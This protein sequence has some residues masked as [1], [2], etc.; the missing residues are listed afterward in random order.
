MS[1]DDIYQKLRDRPFEPF[2][3]HLSDGR[4]FDVPHPERAVIGG[5]RMTIAIGGDPD[6]VPDRLIDC[7]PYHIV[8]VEPLNG[9]SARNGGKRK[10]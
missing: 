9:K 2:R 10:R 7:D 5:H 8:T 4:S 1:P 3:V 6:R